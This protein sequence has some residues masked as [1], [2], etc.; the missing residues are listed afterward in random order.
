MAEDAAV[1]ASQALREVTA[2]TEDSVCQDWQDTGSI[3]KGVRLNR[4]KAFKLSSEEH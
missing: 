3:I 4:N 2:G 1:R